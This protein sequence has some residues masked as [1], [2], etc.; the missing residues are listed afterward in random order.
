MLVD[1]NREEKKRRGPKKAPAVSLRNDDTSFRS[2]FLSRALF[3]GVGA[4]QG[5][6]SRFET[7]FALAVVVLK[8]GKKGLVHLG[9]GRPPP[10]NAT[11]D[12]GD[13]ELAAASSRRS[14][15]AADSHS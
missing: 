11:S 6:P 12:D 15:A 13:I 9:S 7:R 5:S 10:T 3:D 1:K 4:L 14:A 2:V 8:R